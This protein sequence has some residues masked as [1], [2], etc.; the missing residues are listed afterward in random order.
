MPPII[1]LVFIS[2]L[3]YPPTTEDVLK[4]Q[5]Y[6]LKPLRCPIQAIRLYQ[7]ALIRREYPI[8]TSIQVQDCQ[9]IKTAED[10]SAVRLIV[11]AC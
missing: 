2:P 1:L 8:K 9:K 5:K 3:V 6:G 7:N 11:L 4:Q 10:K